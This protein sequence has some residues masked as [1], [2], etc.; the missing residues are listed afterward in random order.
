M[1]LCHR[2]G[3]V[4]PLFYSG[5]ELS[6]HSC[7]FQAGQIWTFNRDLLLDYGLAVLSLGTEFS[8]KVIQ[9]ALWTAYVGF[10]FFTEN[11]VSLPSHYLWAIRLGIFIFVIFSFEGFVMGSRMSHTVGASDG[12]EGY[13]FLNWSKKF[14]DL[15]ISHFLGM[16]AL[17]VLPL[18]AHYLFKSN[19]AVIVFGVIYFLIT[20]F[21]LVVT[22][23]GKAL[24]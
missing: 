13:Y 15:R 16:H 9:L 5:Q 24:L 12:S 7:F 22:L 8:C 4:G 6:R 23:M 2:L 19:L 14:G 1:Q 17:Q 11:F 10:L 18:A 21:V 3:D 20:A